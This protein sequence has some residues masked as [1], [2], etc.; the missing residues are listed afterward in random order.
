MENVMKMNYNRCLR[1]TGKNDLPFSILLLGCG[2]LNAKNFPGTIQLK[3]PF[4]TR[5][6]NFVKKGKKNS[7]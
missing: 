3:S 4:S 1:D 6:Q 7:L 5:W 2:P